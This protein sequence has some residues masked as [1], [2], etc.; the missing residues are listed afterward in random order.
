M[1]HLLLFICAIQLLGCSPFDIIEGFKEA[2]ECSGLGGR[3]AT[4]AEIKKREE[5]EKQGKKWNGCP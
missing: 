2:G 1:K 3:K 5:C 4:P